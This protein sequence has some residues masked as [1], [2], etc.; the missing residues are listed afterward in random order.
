VSIDLPLEA[1]RHARARIA[2]R[3]RHTPLLP[4]PALHDGLPDGLR[5]KL[6]NLQVTGS[7][8]VRGAFNTLLQLTP[9][10]RARGIVAASGGNHGV[11]V[12]YAARQL[13]IPATIYLPAGASDDRVAR[14][15]RWE[16]TVIRHGAAWDDAHARALAHAAA[17]DLTSIHPF[18]A[19]AVIE[20]Q[21]TLGLE[22]L[23]DVPD[24]DAVL[25]AIG[26]GGLI[27]GVA[28]AIKQ[29][30]PQARVIGV[31]PVGASSMA[32]SL[33]AGRLVTL[34]AVHTIADTL[35]PRAVAE[36]TLALAARFVDDIVL[37]SDAQMVDA[38]RWLWEE[39]NQL[40]EPAGAAAIAGLL[41][42]GA[43]VEGCARPVV[44]VCGGNAAAGPVFDA[45]A[46]A[47]S[48]PS[49]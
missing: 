29:V 24:L 6:E 32:D 23:D 16:A 31:E 35:A 10:Q 19:P 2:G 3:V 48:T 37:V 28:A 42:R 34:P 45:Y 18:D 20:G 38:M 9:A 40:V 39:C 1:I 27:G 46:A 11:A 4:S 47:G 12:A 22:L 15:A 41:A 36:H 49:T 7:F 30:R 8:K 33:H 14:V 43:L 17:D 25:V 13:G 26:G 44:L 5:L 21:A